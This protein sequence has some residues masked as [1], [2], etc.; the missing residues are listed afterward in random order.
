M[1]HPRVE[2]SVY[3]ID[4]WSEKEIS[5][6]GR[7][8]AAE[9]EQKHRAKQLEMG[10][11]YPEEKQTF[12]FLGRGQLQAHSVR[13]ADLDVVPKEPPVRHADVVGWPP[14][15]SNRKVDEAAQMA[16]ALKLQAKAEY[17]P[18]AC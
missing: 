3:R 8:V 17:I 14:L 11:P 15:S 18:A 13:S 5:D 6:K 16:Y 12:R 10:L 4:G 2:L 7:E 9:R 1:P